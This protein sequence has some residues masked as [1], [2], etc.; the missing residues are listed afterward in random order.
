MTGVICTACSTLNCA[1]CPGN[2]CSACKQGFYFS[3]GSCLVS[4]ALNCLE[5]KSGSS[6]LCNVC[7]DGYFKGND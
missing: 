3:G 2:T 1:I 4:S 5:P 7:L 6:T